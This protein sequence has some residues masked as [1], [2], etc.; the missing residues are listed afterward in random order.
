MP[1]LGRFVEISS[2]SNMGDFQARR[3]KMRFRPARSESPR[4]LHTLNA[5]GLAVGRCLA[6][7]WENYQREDGSIHIP[8]VLVPY[9]GGQTEIV[10][11]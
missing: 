7:I 5:S 9:M 10:A 6:S 4:L 3:G 11:P 1:S 2:C 8:T